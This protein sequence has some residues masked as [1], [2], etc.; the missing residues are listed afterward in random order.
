MAPEI[1]P[2]K[3]GSLKGWEVGGEVKNDHGAQIIHFLADLLFLSLKVGE[4]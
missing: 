1:I 2:R 3:Q 4:S